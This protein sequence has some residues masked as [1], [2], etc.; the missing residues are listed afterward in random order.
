MNRVV[1]Q[2]IR[3]QASIAAMKGI[4]E[5]SGLIL[6]QVEGEK[7]PIRL[8]RFSYD[9]A[10]RMAVNYADALIAELEKEGGSNE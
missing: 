10:A 6:T 7:H 1:K 8:P 3:V 2:I 4:I 5:T 9:E